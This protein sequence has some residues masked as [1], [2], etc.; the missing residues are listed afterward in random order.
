MFQDINSYYIVQHVILNWI[1]L[2]LFKVYCMTLIHSEFFLAFQ[3]EI[4]SC[5]MVQL[6]IFNT[7][8]YILWLISELLLHLFNSFFVNKNLW[9]V[10][11]SQVRLQKT[12]RQGIN[13]CWIHIISFIVHHNLFSTWSVLNLHVKT[14]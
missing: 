14:F 6:I 13:R 11:G 12:L 5:G 4:S 9:C 10:Q 3:K 7:V 1:F 2:I 8:N